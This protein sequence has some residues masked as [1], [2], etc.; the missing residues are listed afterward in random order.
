MPSSDVSGDS[1]DVLCL[2]S[3]LWLPCKVSKDDLQHAH[4]S[5]LQKIKTYTHN[6]LITVSVL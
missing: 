1:N 6:P 5:K 3:I 2:A 4:I